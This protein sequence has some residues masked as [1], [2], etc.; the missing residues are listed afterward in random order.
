[1][2]E[3]AIRS[4]GMQYI[5]QGGFTTL[6]VDGQEVWQEGPDCHAPEDM[7]LS[8]D[9]S[10]FVQCIQTLVAERDASEPL[11]VKISEL[12]SALAR[13]VTEWYKKDEREVLRDTLR[14][15]SDTLSSP[16]EPDEL[17]RS[18]LTTTAARIQQACESLVN[19]LKQ[20]REKLKQRD[21]AEVVYE[22]MLAEIRKDAAKTREILGARPDETIMDAAERVMSGHKTSESA[23]TLEFVPP[24]KDPILSK[25]QDFTECQRIAE[26]LFVH[27]TDQN[28][29]TA[30]ENAVRF[31]RLFAIHKERIAE[32]GEL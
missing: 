10:A 5:T 32:G 19:Q 7:Y 2:T 28:E 12:E 4:T 22:R 17:A 16:L 29:H 8:R 14:C 24:S 31:M 23:Q 13:K 27:R 9:L 20:E 15:L 25:L 21:Y 11:K 3:E 18:V 6:Y 26:L 30:Y 1:M